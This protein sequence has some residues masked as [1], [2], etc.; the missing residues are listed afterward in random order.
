MAGRSELALSLTEINVGGKVYPVRTSNFAERGKRSFR[1]TARNS[2]LGA[3]VGAAFGGKKGAGQ[4]A[5][6]GAA[7]S[8]LRRGDSVTVPVGAILEFRLLQSF[9]IAR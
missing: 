9:Q 4:G 7:T 5:A 6:V 2:L 3:A 1:K 8:V